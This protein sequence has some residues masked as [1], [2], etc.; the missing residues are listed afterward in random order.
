M[1]P[2]GSACSPRLVLVVE[3]STIEI[4]RGWARAD[5]E[6]L[7]ALG[8]EDGAAL[9]ERGRRHADAAVTAAFHLFDAFWRR[10]R[11]ATRRA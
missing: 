3:D 10:A 8:I 11:S 5:G 9:L 6:R 2:S 7:R 4:V 1:T